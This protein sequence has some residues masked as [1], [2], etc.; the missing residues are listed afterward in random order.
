MFSPELLTCYF[1]IRK[2]WKRPHQLYN[3][4]MVKVNRG[5]HGRQYDLHTDWNGVQCKYRYDAL[6][7]SHVGVAQP[8]TRYPISTS[9]KHQIPNGK[10]VVDG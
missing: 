5:V 8:P 9:F 2:M 1:V 7:V 4:W 10:A 6:E 3:Q